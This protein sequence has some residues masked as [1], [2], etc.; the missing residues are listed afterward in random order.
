MFKSVLLLGHIRGIRIEL[1]VS[2]VIIVV[3]LLVTMSIGFRQQYPDWSLSVTVATALLTTMVF[4]ASIVAH[5]LGHSLVAIRRGIPVKS[6]TLFIFGGM[7]QMSRDSERADDEFWI[8][9]AG[10]LVS[11]ALAALFGL[12]MLLTAGWYEPLSVALGWLT[13]INLIVAVFNMIPGFPLDGGRV[14]RALVWKY[15]G[16]ARK[17]ITAALAGG[18]VVAYTLFG[19]ALVNILL[20]GNLIGGLWI[21]LIAWFLLNM[22]EGQGRMFDLRERLSGVRARDVADSEVP[23]VSPDSN[24]D[25]WIH[26]QVLPGGRRAFLVGNADRALGLI[27]LSDAR[28]VP[29]DQWR[30]TRVTDV[31]TPADKLIHVTA[32]TGTN[33]ILQLISDR[34][35][36]QIPV[37]ENN[38]VSGWIDRHRLLRAI[39]IHMEIKQ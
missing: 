28:K 11:L 8:A 4:F 39:D 2:W 6:I 9:I 1:H 27:T 25:D 21:M 24:L 35:L 26:R 15:T 33:E 10:P 31:M 18:R 17:G 3:L 23:V 36:N 34:N 5:E 37:M 20:A 16:D 29:Q 30:Q 14:L 19:L 32:D 22:A 38:R 7:A 13:I 12:L